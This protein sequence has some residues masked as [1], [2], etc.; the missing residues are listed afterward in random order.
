MFYHLPP[1]FFSKFQGQNK[2][3][4]WIST[5]I[6]W[7]IRQVKRPTYSDVMNSECPFAYDY[8]VHHFIP[9]RIWYELYTS[10]LF[11]IIVLDP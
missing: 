8:V 3:F 4:L 9:N 1:D 6:Q 10:M 11:P 5:P 2:K 7:E